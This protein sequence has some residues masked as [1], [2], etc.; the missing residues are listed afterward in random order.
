[1]KRSRAL[2]T[3]G[4]ATGTAGNPVGVGVVAAAAAAVG[5]VE[6]ADRCEIQRQAR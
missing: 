5:G 1:V 2:V 6:N 3:M 4:M